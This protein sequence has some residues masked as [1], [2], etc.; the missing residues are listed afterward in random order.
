VPTRFFPSGILL[1]AIVLASATI[2]APPAAGQ[3]GVD[4]DADVESMS[5]VELLEDFAYFVTIRQDELAKSYANAILD[6]DLSPREF[7]GIV[8]DDPQVRRK[9]DDTVRRAMF[10]P[11]LEDSAARLDRLYEEG[12]LSRARDPEEIARNIQLLTENPRARMLAKDRLSFAGEYA[13]PQL[14]QVLLDRGNPALEGQVQQVLIEMGGDAVIP[15]A[16]AFREVDGATQEKLA[17]ILG[18]IQYGAA[19]PYLYEVMRDTGSASVRNACTRAIAMLQGDAAASVSVAD[20]YTELADSYYAES[21]SLTRFPDEE[22]QLLWS[23]DPRSGLNMTAIRSEVFHEARAM[24]LAERAMSVDDDNQRAASLWL[25]ANF[26]REI[27]QPQGYDNP[28]YDREHDA[29]YY[30]VA[31]GSAPTQRVL[32]RALIDLDTPLARRVIDA[33]S[34]GAGG[35]GLWQGLG[36]DRPLLDALG[37]PDRRVQYEAA[38]A[39]GRAKPRSSFAGAERVTPILASA[40]RDAAARYAVVIASEASRR[41]ELFSILEDRGYTVLQ[42]GDSLDDVASAVANAA[43]VEMI[44]ADLGRDATMSLLDQVR[45]SA[46]LGVTPVLAL[47]PQSAWTELWPR[48]DSDPLT[49]LRREGVSEQQIATSV[50][51]LALTATGPAVTDEQARQYALDSLAVLRDLAISRN[52][53]FQVADAAP[54]LIQAMDETEGE[55]R[56]RVADVLA[57]VEESRAQVALMDAALDATGEQ[58]VALLARVS[59]SAKSYGNMLE[60]RQ[61]RDLVDLASTAES[62]EV[63]TAAAALVGVLNLPQNS[64]TTIILQNA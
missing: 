64:L 2:T 36:D 56:L 34:L 23:F 14:L 42:S 12:R 24:S 38:L 46:K 6:R 18:R 50:D 61:V 57:T 28:A 16:V 27:D 51:Q 60:D 1:S 47:L 37:Y 32:S 8:E 5:T 25:A 4:A 49:E 54:S 44:I 19:L 22:F 20:L 55:V 15:L 62:T 13:V 26:S 30:A 59:E 63:A 9:F 48:Y 21:E 33:L 17:L 58:Q 10:V 41:Q 53:V 40:V 7:V 29:L 3:F 43:G 35:A 11:A 31:A 39:I 45:S 52:P